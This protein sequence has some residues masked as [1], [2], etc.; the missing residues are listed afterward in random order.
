MF[1]PSRT[2]I[3]PVFIFTLALLG[4]FIPNAQAQ[5]A[6]PSLLPGFTADNPAALQWSGPSR[7]GGGYLKSESTATNVA[8]GVEVGTSDFKGV[9]LGLALIGETTSLG[10]AA[11]DFEGN[12]SVGNT[13]GIASQAANI[14]L[15]L[16]DSVALGVALEQGKFTFEGTIPTFGTG[17][18]EYEIDTTL[19]GVSVR[20]F[21]ILYLGGAYGTETQQQTID[22]PGAPFYV[23]DELDRIVRRYGV[24]FFSRE[25]TKWHLEYSVKYDEFAQDTVTSIKINEVEETRI[26]LEFQAGSILLGINSVKSVETDKSVTP[27]TSSETNTNSATLGWLPDTAWSLIL[28]VSQSENDDGT[29]LSEGDGLAVFLGYLF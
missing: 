2:F 16:G 5:V 6:A 13:I 10:I 28:V 22:F 9:L 26:E 1:V 11:A 15:Q 25:G 18:A 24:G 20:L 29:T 23:S 7:I 3:L 4:A 17:T 8:S 14:A 19:G 21:D 12:D 27:N